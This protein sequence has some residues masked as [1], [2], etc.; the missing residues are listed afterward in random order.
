[1]RLVV[2]DGRVGGCPGGLPPLSA[3]PAATEPRATTAA[4]PRGLPLLSPPLSPSH[5]GRD[6]LAAWAHVRR[7][8]VPVHAV[9]TATAGRSDDVLAA[10]PDVLGDRRAVDRAIGCTFRARSGSSPVAV[11]NVWTARDVRGPAHARRVHRPT[12][13]GPVHG[14]TC[15]QPD[16]HGPGVRTA[17]CTAR[18]CTA[19][20]VHG[21]VARPDVGRPETAGARGG[22]GIRTGAA[23]DASPVPS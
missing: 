9:T 5:D 2:P 8:H 23:L 15:P 14:P 20:R 3:G 16:D 6:R 18:L 13:R 17:G 10:P 22:Q 19:R 1:M 4:A 12:A 7:R 11:T 21:P